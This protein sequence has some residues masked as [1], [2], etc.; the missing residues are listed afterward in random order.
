MA[1]TEKNLP[2]IWETWVWSL[3]GEDP[4]EKVMATH[5]SILACQIRWTEEPAGLRSM[6]LQRVGHDWATNIFFS[7]PFFFFSLS[8]REECQEMVCRLLSIRLCRHWMTWESLDCSSC[9]AK[10]GS[11]TRLSYSGQ[12]SWWWGG[13]L[14]HCS[15][16][17][18][19]KWMNEEP[20][21]NLKKRSNQL[22]FKRWGP[23]S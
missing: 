4:L 16:S 21:K 14:T 3:G 20:I 18:C 9:T 12:Q 13:C 22:R 1:Q 6:G 7:K 5:S 19:I 8:G 11:R 17:V 2:T 15:C 10:C 23:H